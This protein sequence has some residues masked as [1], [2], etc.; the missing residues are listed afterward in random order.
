MKAEG[1]RQK[2]KGRDPRT[3]AEWQEAADVAEFMR[4]LHSARLYGLVCGGPH[5]DVDRCE[6]IL[7][8]TP[9]NA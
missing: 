8:P 3:R 1:K 5:V 4:Y 9:L 7:L 6:H 2:A